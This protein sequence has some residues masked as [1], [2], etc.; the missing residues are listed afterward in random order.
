MPLHLQVGLGGSIVTP[1]DRGR[2]AEDSGVEDGCGW[3]GVILP[4]D[5]SVGL[6]S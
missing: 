4:D 6:A 3:N 5:G 2:L 1:W